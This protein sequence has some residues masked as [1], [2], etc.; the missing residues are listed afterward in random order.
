MSDLKRQIAGLDRARADLEGHVCEMEAWTF[1]GMH[2]RA[3]Y[4]RAA[5]EQLP[6]HLRWELVEGPFFSKAEACRAVRQA[7]GRPKGRVA[8]SVGLHGRM[9]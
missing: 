9:R 5:A 6:E 3:R 2:W 4:R 7:A 8:T 1:D